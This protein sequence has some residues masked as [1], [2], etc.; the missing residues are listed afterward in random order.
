MATII[1]MSRMAAMST[2][3]VVNAVWKKPAIG[4]PAWVRPAA[5]ENLFRLLLLLLLLL[6]RLPGAGRIF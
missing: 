1:P 3:M 4:F 5:A 6:L 2:V